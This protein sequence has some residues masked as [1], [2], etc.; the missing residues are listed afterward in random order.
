MNTQGKPFRHQRYHHHRELCRVIYYRLI[1][2]APRNHMANCERE[3][4]SLIACCSTENPSSSFTVNVVIVHTP[5]STLPDHVFLLLLSL[6]ISPIRVMSRSKPNSAQETAS[7]VSISQNVAERWQN[8]NST[9]VTCTNFWSPSLRHSVAA[10]LIP[11]S[12]TQSSAPS[13]LL[14]LAL[15]KVPE[16]ISADIPSFG[17]ERGC[18]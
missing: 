4:T 16:P 12:K 14:L 17:I 2:P 6:R 1:E 7:Q 13:N 3:K 9:S 11:I 18:W 10:F 5:A 15:P 8:G